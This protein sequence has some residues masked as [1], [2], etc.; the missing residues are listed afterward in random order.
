VSPVRGLLAWAGWQHHRDT[1]AP[2][3]RR[4]LV[5][6]AA[7]RIARLIRPQFDT[8][9][10]QVRLSDLRDVGPL[11]PHEEFVPADLRRPDEI[12]AAVAGV[13]AI[14]HFG[15]V[16]TTDD[17]DSL[18]PVNVGGTA[19]LLTAARRSGVETV[20]LASTMHVVGGY[21]RTE[22]IS[23]QSAPR[24][25]SPYGVSK[26]Y[27]EQLAA[28]SSFRYGSRII[29]L[30]IG[31]V[32]MDPFV[33]EPAN[34]IAPDDLVALLRFALTE[35]SIT[36][37]IIHGVAPYRGDDIGQRALERQFGFRFRHHGGTFR[38]AMRDLPRHY[39]H[40]AVARAMRGGVFASARPAEPT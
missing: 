3:C 40:D 29:C 31:H 35:R 14:V 17:N 12:A 5:T 37:K 28:V 27:G 39:P 11:A 26:L 6:G 10:E 32:T 34:W 36:F 1:P 15:G 21:R 7:G 8:L 25:D 30:R 4:L 13:D 24:P 23:P 19:S 33:A 38:A 2:R 16:S 9:A 18:I 22:R 20:V